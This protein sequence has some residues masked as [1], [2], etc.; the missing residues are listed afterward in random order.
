M[1][2]VETQRSFTAPTRRTTLRKKPCVYRITAAISR[3][4]ITARK[5]QPRLFF[6][7]PAMV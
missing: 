4:A 3:T 1:S 7:P 6:R 2:W 5:I